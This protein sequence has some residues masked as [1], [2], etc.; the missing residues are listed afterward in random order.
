MRREFRHALNIY[1]HRPV[2]L[3]VVFAVFPS[4]LDNLWADVIGDVFFGPAVRGLHQL[5]KAVSKFFNIFLRGKLLFGCHKVS[6]GYV[7]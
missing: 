1:P 3:P 2:F 5:K 7:R 6:R 4:S